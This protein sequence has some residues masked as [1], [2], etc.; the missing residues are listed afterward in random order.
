MSSK[1]IQDDNHKKNLL[2]AFVTWK[3]LH[4][5]CHYFTSVNPSIRILSSCTNTNYTFKK[6]YWSSYTV[7]NY[8]FLSFASVWVKT[9]N[10]SCYEIDCIGHIRTTKTLLHLCILPQQLQKN[11]L[12]TLFIGPNWKVFL[13]EMSKNLVS[14][15]NETLEVF[16]VLPN[17]KKM[18]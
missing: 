11:S 10:R 13:D 9:N 18:L 17:K 12:L 14:K 15:M 7:V 4:A 1:M 2:L 5:D 16:K 3:E 6:N 8:S